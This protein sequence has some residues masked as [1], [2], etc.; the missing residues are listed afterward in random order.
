MQTGKLIITAAIAQT[1]RFDITLYCVQSKL[2]LVPSMRLHL[3]Y[4]IC[5]ACSYSQS[6]K[7]AEQLEYSTVWKPGYGNV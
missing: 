5:V 3:G 4:A 7:A 1:I 6:K 2:I